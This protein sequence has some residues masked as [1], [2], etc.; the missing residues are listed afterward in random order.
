VSERSCYPAACRHAAEYL[1]AAAR[2]FEIKRKASVQEVREHDDGFAFRYV[3]DPAL[4]VRM[5]EL[6][7]LEHRCRPF[8]T[9]MAGPAAG[10]KP[11]APRRR[12]ARA[13]GLIRSFSMVTFDAAS[14][15]KP[16]SC[17][18]SSPRV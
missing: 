1:G 3:A 10:A 18:R 8:L 16:P 11:V 9:L 7:A 5:A 12:L 13:R 15:A 4:F 17:R 6:V 2:V 14:A